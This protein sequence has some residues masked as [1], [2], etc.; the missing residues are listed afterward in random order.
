MWWQRPAN[1]T[2]LWSALV[3]CGAPLVSWAHILPPARV[4]CTHCLRPLRPSPCLAFAFLFF[5]FL[6]V[7]TLMLGLARVPWITSGHAC[8]LPPLY[9]PFFLPLSLYTAWFYSSSFSSTLLPLRLFLSLLSPSNLLRQPFPSQL[10]ATTCIR[11]C[12]ARDGDQLTVGACGLLSR[13]RLY[14]R[15]DVGRRYLAAALPPSEGM[16]SVPINH[17]PH[18]ASRRTLIGQCHRRT[19]GLPPSFGMPRFDR[20]H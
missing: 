19:H 4:S 1:I 6:Q 18:V 13:L 10:P 2:L 9:A 11:Q 8:S 20:F 5:P 16:K 14:D 17:P 15:S 3:S 7:L 12:F